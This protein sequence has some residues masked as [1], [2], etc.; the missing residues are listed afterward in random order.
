M[1]PTKPKP[2]EPSLEPV[3][4]F[5][6]ALVAMFIGAILTNLIFIFRGFL[7]EGFIALFLSKKLIYAIYF[8][9]F[10]VCGEIIALTLLIAD[11]VNLSPC[12][13][14]FWKYIFFQE[15]SREGLLAF[16]SALAVMI[17]GGHIGYCL[18]FHPLIIILNS[19][20]SALTISF[21][22]K[23][24]VRIS[25]F[26]KAIVFTVLAF[27]FVN[28]CFLL[29]NPPLIGNPVLGDKELTLLHLVSY[30]GN[31]NL[32]RILVRRGA[33]V[34]AKDSRDGTPLCYAVSRNQIKVVKLLIR[35]GA[36]VNTTC[37]QNITPLHLATKNGYTGIVKALIQADA[38]I[39]F[40]D[41]QDLLMLRQAATRGYT[42]IIRALL[43]TA[44]NPSEVST[45][46]LFD[47]V[48]SG[49][50]EVTKVLLEVGADVTVIPIKDKEIRPRIRNLLLQF[51]KP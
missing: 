37:N 1:K 3:L 11:R 25:K 35:L 23:D 12:E 45:Q 9:A 30:M 6:G 40:T 28:F 16:G 47:T 13:L 36:D 42:E 43:E 34:N 49:W 48:Y 18:S 44:E 4:I 20:F 5:S 24:K 10:A 46:I 8:L 21:V 22:I 19:G 50:Y 41:E 15:S 29:T 32:A 33:D 38:D 14:K 2:L 31:S 39:D 26:F 17:L 51:Q 7:P 27:V